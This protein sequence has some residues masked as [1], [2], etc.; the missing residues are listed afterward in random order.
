[1]L[2]ARQENQGMNGRDLWYAWLIPL[3]NRFQHLLFMDFCGR[4][5]RPTHTRARARM[6]LKPNEEQKGRSGFDDR[7]GFLLAY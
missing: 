7:I 5:L 2:I 4:V 6:Q 1:M 3:S